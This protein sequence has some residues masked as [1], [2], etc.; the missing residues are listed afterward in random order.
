MQSTLFLKS[1]SSFYEIGR[2]FQV[3]QFRKKCIRENSVILGSW[4]CSCFLS[5]T[6]RGTWQPCML[7][8]RVHS[9][10]E[11]VV[12]PNV[13]YHKLIQAIGIPLKISAL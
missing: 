7:L 12:Y 1:L 5:D 11:I 4:V 9:N 8:T 13:L 2:N 6:E 10:Q 3:F